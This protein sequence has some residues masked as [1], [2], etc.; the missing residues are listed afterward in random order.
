MVNPNPE[1]L[2]FN[3]T[4]LNTHFGQAIATPWATSVLEGS[5]IVLL[6]EVL[7]IEPLKVQRNLGAIGLRVAVHNEHAG[8][9]IAVSDRFKSV[10]DESF[11]LQKRSKL[12]D[13]AKK[14]GVE[15]RFRERGMLL[16]RLLDTKCHNE[17]FAAT[18]H[19]VVAVRLLARA[20]QVNA[21]TELMSHRYATGSF[22]LGA[23]MNHY[24]AANKVDVRM[25][26]SGRLKPVSNTDPTCLLSQTRHSW[27]RHLGFSDARLD[28]M[29][30]RSLVELS[31]EVIDAQSD[32]KAIRAVFRFAA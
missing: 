21:I 22:I 1:Q 9:V 7:D 3:V 16:T 24:P 27:L 32:H 2:P 11:V 28:T 8:L 30:F 17:L 10:K 4:T 18:A 19:P 13:V 20:N 15:Q 14:V 6:Q 12:A 31:S 5:D 29:L 23:D 26:A 25:A